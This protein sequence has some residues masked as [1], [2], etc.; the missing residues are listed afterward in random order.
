MTEVQLSSACHQAL[1][2]SAIASKLEDP[3]SPSNATAAYH[4][5]AL[6]AQARPTGQGSMSQ[7]ATP[8]KEDA[9]CRI[10]TN[11]ADAT[12]EPRSH[13][14]TWQLRWETDAPR[15]FD[16][17]KTWHRK[18]KSKCQNLA[19]RASNESW[20]KFNR[21]LS[22]TGVTKRYQGERAKRRNEW[23]SQ[24]RQALTTSP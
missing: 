10:R 24:Q 16:P 17:A 5:P 3:A 21:E 1:R 4:R 15:N 12:A 2:S 20:W 11:T 22:A 8:R 18:S 14:V 7:N 19:S 13:L 9:S 23:K 6:Q